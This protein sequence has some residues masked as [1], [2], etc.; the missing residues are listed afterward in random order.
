[1]EPETFEVNF[2]A[3]VPLVDEPPELQAVASRATDATTAM[4][5]AVFLS[6]MQN[7]FRMLYTSASSSTW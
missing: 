4:A 5:A 6:F 1:M 2:G 7:P 3:A